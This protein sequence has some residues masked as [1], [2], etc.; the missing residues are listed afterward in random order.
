MANGFFDTAK[1][2]LLRPVETFRRSQGESFESAFVYFV[3]LLVV[4]AVLTALISLA[5][6]AAAPWVVAPAAPE[7]ATGSVIF[8]LL[9]FFSTVIG[10]IILLFAGGLI[11]HLFVILLGGRQG[12]TETLKAFMYGDTPLLLLGWIPIIGVLAALY[13]IVLW[14]IGIHELQQISVIRAALSLILP[15]AIALIIAILLLAALI[16][17]LIGFLERLLG[18]VEQFTSLL[19]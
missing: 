19:G 2:F 12:V 17:V 10:N 16:A 5:G 18:S 11:V 7:P 1:G 13:S 15:V 3:I 6:I 14:I 9:T 8:I 4:N